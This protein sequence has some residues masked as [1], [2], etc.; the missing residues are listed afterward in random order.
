MTNRA[1]YPISAEIPLK[2]GSLVL[3][4]RFSNTR[5]AIKVII[6]R[7]IVELY[8]VGKYETKKLPR[9]EWVEKYEYG[10]KREKLERYSK[11][12]S[13]LADLSKLEQLLFTQGDQL[14]RSV[15]YAFRKLGF[16]INIPQ[17][18]GP[19]E[20][21]KISLGDYKAIIEVK[22]KKTHATLTDL[23][24]LLQYY[25]DKKEFSQETNIQA[26]FVVNHYFHEDLSKRKNPYV[27]EALE[28]A[29]KY[30]ISLLTTSDLYAIIEKCL[31]DEALTKVV[32][33]KIV[34]GS[35]YIILD[36]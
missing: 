4:P 21:I 8:N 28:L 26:I 25:I 9:P 3:L 14:R 36:R 24:Q 29:N 30:N 2:K 23:R 32:Q 33:E 11:L 15:A 10:I 18:K 17:E 6:E 19:I 27:K 5:Y 22:G 12:E 35:G 20:D 1:G 16:Y 31:I 34:K 13:E 7:I